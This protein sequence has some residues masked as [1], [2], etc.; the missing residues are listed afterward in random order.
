MRWSLLAAVSVSPV[1]LLSLAGFGAAAPSPEAHRIS[2]PVVHENLAVY[3][4]H[5]KSAPGKVPLTLEEAMAKGLVKVRETSN[6]NQLQIEN[7]GADEVFVQ[8]GDIVKG[9]K[10]DR[11][12]MVSLVLPPKSGAIP[13]ASFC[14]EQGRWSARGREDAKN[15]STAS[16]AVPSR[17]M[18]LAM[19]APMQAKPAPEPGNMAG[20]GDRGRMQMSDNS[21]ASETG[22]RQQKVWENVRK[23]QSKLTG[24]IGASVQSAQSG[25]SLQLAL[26]NEKLMDAQKVYINALKAAGENSDDIVGFI[27]AVNGE[28]NSADV[29]PS[30]GLFRKMWAKLLTA[31]VIEAIGHKDEPAVAAPDAAA[32]SAFLAAAEAGKSSEKSLN[33]GVKLETREADKAYMFETARAPSPGAPSAPAAWVHRNYLAK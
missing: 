33:D 16:A 10:Q 14:V 30:N 18:K 21:A 15:F 26:E 11:T 5:G 13:I 6:V 3:F 29:Y 24:N 25:S 8:S 9:G 2:G 1:M 31:S 28:L 12:L 7:V 23:T 19:K 4:I 17:E 20:N 32:A 22:A 27:F